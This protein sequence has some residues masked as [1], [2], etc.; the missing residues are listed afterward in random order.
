MLY[1]RQAAHFFALQ[2]KLFAPRVG[3]FLFALAP[4]AYY[5]IGAGFVLSAFVG[6]EVLVIF[7]IV[8]VL[9]LPGGHLVAIKVVLEGFAVPESFP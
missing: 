1:R 6:H 7:R 8:V 3:L 4:F 2:S 9:F 5:D